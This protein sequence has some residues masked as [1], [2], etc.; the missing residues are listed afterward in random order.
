M[1]RETYIKINKDYLKEI[2]PLKI[3][4]ELSILD[5][6]DLVFEDCVECVLENYDEGAIELTL[7]SEEKRKIVH[8]LIYKDEPL[9]E[10]IND[11]IRY[12]IRQALESREHNE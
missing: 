1:N 7:T 2:P 9:W 10:Y 3:K 12:E 5:M 8:S 4:E 11:T 6:Y